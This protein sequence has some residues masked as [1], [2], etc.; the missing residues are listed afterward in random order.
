ML[1]IQNGIN[2]WLIQHGGNKLDTKQK[3]RKETDWNSSA[4]NATLL[5]FS[6]EVLTNAFRPTKEIHK[7]WKEG[8]EILICRLIIV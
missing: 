3:Q 4:L 6:L 7:D 5:N 8:D 1:M 2:I